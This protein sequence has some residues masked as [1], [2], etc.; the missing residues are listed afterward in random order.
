MVSREC[1]AL[2]HLLTH[3]AIL[4]KLAEARCLHGPEARGAED[5]RHPQPGPGEGS[6]L[7]L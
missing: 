5:V 1:S 4:L 2:C 7:V 6:A 3:G